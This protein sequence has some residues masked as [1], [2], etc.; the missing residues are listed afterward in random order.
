M[1]VRVGAF[2]AVR[3]TPR[4]AMIICRGQHSRE[5][6]PSVLNSTHLP[7]ASGH[8]EL[9]DNGVNT[10]PV[11]VPPTQHLRRMAPKPVMSRKRRIM[12]IAV[13]S[14]ERQIFSEILCNLKAKVEWCIL[15]LL[16]VSVVQGLQQNRFP[17]EMMSRIVMEGFLQASLPGSLRHRHITIPLLLHQR[18]V[19]LL[20][21]TATILFSTGTAS[22]CKGDEF[23]SELEF[24]SL[25]EKALA[26]LVKRYPRANCGRSTLVH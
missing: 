2:Q 12:A 17:A 8:D 25:T 15:T 9:K 24:Q 22:S 4:R 18:M 20:E 16:S 7:D 10:L 5:T 1:W 3:V 19:T 21:R 26:L 23:T 6:P 14:H 11:L 13:H